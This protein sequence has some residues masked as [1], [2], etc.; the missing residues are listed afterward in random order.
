MTPTYNKTCPECAQAFRTTNPA[1]RFCTV[2]HKAAFANR[3]SA[4]GRG[5]LVQDALAWRASRNSPDNREIGRAAFGRMCQ[6]LDQMLREDR[7]AGRSA[8]AYVRPQ[9]IQDGLI[10][11]VS[12]PRP[13]PA[14]KA[15]AR[16]RRRGSNLVVAGITPT[17]PISLNQRVVGSNPT[18]PTIVPL[19]S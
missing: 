3:N 7:A 13:A 8:M 14:P 10:K 15:P 18:S 9:L 1:Q 17:P 11:R 4:R 16:P 6:S 5:G 12:L 19:N 2:A